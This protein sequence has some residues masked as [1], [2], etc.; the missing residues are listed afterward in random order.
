MRL[1]IAL[2]LLI[3]FGYELESYTPPDR[4][5]TA[6]ERRLDDRYT[7]GKIR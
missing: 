3:G 6:V 7:E 5:P 1:L 4:P 2:A